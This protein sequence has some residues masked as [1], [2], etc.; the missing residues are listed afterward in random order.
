[1][2]PPPPPFCVPRHR[3]GNCFLKKLLISGLPHLPDFCLPTYFL[4]YISS[5]WN[6]WCGVVFLA[7]TEIFPKLV[8]THSCICLHQRTVKVHLIRFV[9]T[10]TD[11][12]LFRL[13]NRL[14][15]MLLG[16]HIK[17]TSFFL[18]FSKTTE[19]LLFSNILLGISLYPV[20]LR[21]E[22]KIVF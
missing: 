20:I 1:M 19:R 22:K 3:G 9:W 14:S 21:R 16:A 15:C 2:V 7:D 8:S 10:W 11:A 4:Y 12:Y 6:T 5:L 18:F 17:G 13:A